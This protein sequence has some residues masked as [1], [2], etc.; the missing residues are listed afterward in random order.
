MDQGFLMLSNLTSL[1][2]M[3]SSSGLSDLRSKIKTQ[4]TLI[5]KVAPRMVLFLGI[6][7]QGEGRLISMEVRIILPIL[8]FLT[9]ILIEGL[10]ELDLLAMV[11]TATEPIT[12][13]TKV[14]LLKETTRIRVISSLRSPTTNPTCRTLNTSATSNQ[15][16][17]RSEMP[18]LKGL[19]PTCSSTLLRCR[20]TRPPR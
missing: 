1:V 9:P 13:T 6:K 12:R 11:T 14:L 4:G 5:I 16:T 7:T 19:R 10:L 15:W 3:T 2:Q 8:G 20:A 18:A 17:A